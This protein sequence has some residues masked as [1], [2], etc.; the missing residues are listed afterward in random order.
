MKQSEIDR[1][2]V[3]IYRSNSAHDEVNFVRPVGAMDHL[4]MSGLEE[5][6]AMLERLRNDV[7][8]EVELRKRKGQFRYSPNW[9][10]KV[11]AA[12]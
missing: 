6:A 9:Y 3:L 5:Y 2:L 1:A 11:A 10:E 7:E 12:H 8:A 4:P